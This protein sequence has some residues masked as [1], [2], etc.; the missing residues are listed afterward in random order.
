MINKSPWIGVQLKR[1]VER[2][3]DKENYPGGSFSTHTLCYEARIYLHGKSIRIGT[4]ETVE[5]AARAYDNAAFY[6]YL[7]GGKRVPHLNFPNDPPEESLPRTNMLT[8]Q[9]MIDHTESDTLRSDS[10]W[11]RYESNP[12]K[13]GESS[14]S[15]L[16]RVGL[17]ATSILNFRPG[18]PELPQSLKPLTFV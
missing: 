12:P 15:I 11:G 16:L 10:R 18:V 2:N 14:I 13:P 9:Y 3:Y 1:R 5:E 6:L 7:Y 4:Y 17:S 8:T